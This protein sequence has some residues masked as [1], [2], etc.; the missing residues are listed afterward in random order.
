MKNKL[1]GGEYS[2]T[3]LGNKT[4][5]ENKSIQFSRAT[6]VIQKNSCIKNNDLRGIGGKEVAEVKK[7]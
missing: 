3:K 2:L 1:N 5:T 7:L 6:S 4:Q